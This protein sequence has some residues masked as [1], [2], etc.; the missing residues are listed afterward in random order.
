MRQHVDIVGLLWMIWGALQLLG[1][2]VLGAMLLLGS[3]M[4]GLL[5]ADSGDGELL[6]MAGLYGVFGLVLGAFVA[7]F[8]VANVA[9]GW[10]IRGRK[11]WAR[12]GGL[13]MAALAVMNLPVG[14][15]IG[16]FTFMVLLDAEVA[17]EFSAP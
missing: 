14:T 6:V 13:I 3:G 11:P 5:G 4:M 9:V 1:A 16:I 12:I 8:G 10:G 17:E 7:V 15:L 2:L